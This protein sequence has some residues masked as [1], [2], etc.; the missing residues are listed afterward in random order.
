[1]TR[2]SSFEFEDD[3]HEALARAGK[4]LLTAK[5]KDA[6]L[7]LLKVRAWRRPAMHRALFVAAAAALTCL[8]LPAGC[9]GAAGRGCTELR[10]CQ[11]RSA[12]PGQG[13]G[14]QRFFASQG[15]GAVLPPPSPRAASRADRQQ[16]RFKLRQL[17]PPLPLRCRKCASTQPSACATSCACMRPKRHTQTRNCRWV[18]PRS[19]ARPCCHSQLLPAVG[20]EHPIRPHLCTR[21][22]AFAAAA[23][24]L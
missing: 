17:R 4:A 13:R 7:K 23:G 20:G 11:A 14:A 1:M 15:Q 2:R 12:R 10:E 24:H 8:W 6:T 3:D 16:A 19:R 22:D 5:G 18:L 21:P 9:W